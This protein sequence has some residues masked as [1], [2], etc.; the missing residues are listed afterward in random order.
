VSSLAN[1]P[2]GY[3]PAS[4]AHQQQPIPNSPIVTTPGGW[5]RSPDHT[6]IPSSTISHQQQLSN[7]PSTISEGWDRNHYYHGV[8]P[9]ESRPNYHQQPSY[10]T[11]YQ[12]PSLTNLDEGKVENGTYDVEGSGPTNQSKWK[13]APR[14]KLLLAWFAFFSLGVFFLCSLYPSVSSL[15]YCHRICRSCIDCAFWMLFQC[16]QPAVPRTDGALY[17]SQ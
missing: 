2:P 1:H 13:A 3:I 7:V 17:N 4:F 16:H 8:P 6:T 15:I 14:K 5:N 12:E 10:A 11:D 9:P